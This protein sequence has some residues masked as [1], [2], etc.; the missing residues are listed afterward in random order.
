VATASQS[1]EHD[2]KAV[3]TLES[4]LDGTVAQTSVRL[5]VTCV[6]DVP[7]GCANLKIGASTAG[8]PPLTQDIAEGVTTFDQDISL[9]LFDGRQVSVGA[10]ITDNLGRF[11]SA[12]VTVYV[13]G[14]GHLTKVAEVTGP[15]TILDATPDRLLTLD[16]ISAQ[17]Q[18]VGTLKIQQRATGQA[19][20]LMTRKFLE[21]YNAHLTPHGAVFEA[22]D[23]ATSFIHGYEWRDGAL[24]DLGITNGFVV[25]ES[26][27]AW[28]VYN[29][30]IHR[31]NL[32]SGATIVVPGADSNWLSDVG[33]NGDV[34][35]VTSFA[36]IRRFR[37]GVTTTLVPIDPDPN[38]RNGG[39]LT[40]G[41]NVCYGTATQPSAG[42]DQQFQSLIA[43]T[44]AGSD[45]L[46]VYHVPPSGSVHDFSC[47][48]NGGWI[49]FTQPA[50]G[51]TV[52]VWVR[53]PAGIK[54]QASFFSGVSV[55]E[56]VATDGRVVFTSPAAQA[57]RRRYLW[58]PGGSAT[59]IGAGFGQPKLIDGQLYVMLGR[60]LLRVD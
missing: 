33:P 2:R 47:L 52:Q 36:E 39:A 43:L 41:V 56:A 17:D 15:G 18:H 45:T 14:S 10:S 20:D 19:A 30:S 46:L 59:D 1:F 32:E 21:V 27:F 7:S 51:G 29:G 35:Y 58:T 49:G 22:R 13:D 54:T 9:A 6:D 24:L 28:D 5:R 48:L 42:A 8:P 4:P 60:A 26:Y 57:P 53:S 34:L 11:S 44:A 25:D 50:P 37:D 12:S 31:E 40:D 55:L 23:D 16:M 38:L 3:V